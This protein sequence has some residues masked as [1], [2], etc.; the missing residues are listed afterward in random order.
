MRISGPRSFGSRIVCSILLVAQ[1][2]CMAPPRPVGAPVPYLQ[3]NSPKQIWVTL[4]NGDQMVVQSPRL[5][6]DTLLGFTRRGSA[7][8]E[9]WLPVSDLQE[10][11]SRKL[12]GGRTALL[13]GAALVMVGLI[14]AILPKGGSNNPRPCMNE[15]EPCEA[16]N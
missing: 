9:V 8:E 10:V 3:A 4:T 14:V 13:G 16:G 7:N 12:S 1:G 2:A 5:F 11:K 6:G 15:G